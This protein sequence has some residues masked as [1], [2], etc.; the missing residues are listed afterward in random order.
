MPWSE[1]KKNQGLV[2]PPGCSSA[3]CLGLYSQIHNHNVGPHFSRAGW[4]GWTHV[5]SHIYHWHHWVHRTRWMQSWR[6]ESCHHVRS[7]WNCQGYHM[8]CQLIAAVWVWNEIEGL[9]GWRYEAPCWAEVLYVLKNPCGSLVPL[10][11][12]FIKH[13]MEWCRSQRLPTFTE[14]FSFDF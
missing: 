6:H 2:Q 13:Q 3:P 5:A 12:I 7:S 10:C 11:F 1:K 4:S 14:L 9:K 8:N